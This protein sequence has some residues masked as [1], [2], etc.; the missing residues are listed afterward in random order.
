[1]N[2]KIRQNRKIIQRILYMIG[3]SACIYPVISSA[4]MQRYQNNSITTYESAV[5]ASSD[6]KIAEALADAIEYN[7]V[8]YQSETITAGNINTDILSSDN[9][10][11][12]L[13]LADIGIMGSIEIPKI[14]V[15]LPIYHGTSDSVLDTGVGHV[16]QSSLPV[17][18]KNTRAILTGHRGLPN[19]KL[20]T[21]LDELVVGDLFFIYTL[22]Q[23][24]AY[25]V[26]EIEVIKPEEIDK[27]KIQEGKD[28]VTLLTCHPYGINSHRLTI[29]G[30]R[31]PYEQ[32]VYESIESGQMSIREFSF[33]MLPLF[34]IAL[35][36]VIFVRNNRRKKVKK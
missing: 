11:C 23:K 20:F 6:Q 5:S 14:D 7:I 28:L 34:F 15:N 3:L 9:Y 30:E 36:V 12:L 32:E 25:E 2:G 10:D 17:G 22:D 1:M 21:R 31:V 27:L 4:I 35:G 13:N 26:C 8:M 24:M 29:T 19:A 33:Q 16:R 18:G